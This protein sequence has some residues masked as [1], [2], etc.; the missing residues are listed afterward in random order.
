MLLIGMLNKHLLATVQTGKLNTPS[1]STVVSPVDSKDKE[2]KSKL[3]LCNP[4]TN[5]DL[6]FYLIDSLICFCFLI[7]DVTGQQV[8][9]MYVINPS[10][11][12][13]RK[14][15]S[16]MEFVQLEE[17]LKLYGD[18]SL[19]PP[20]NIAQSECARGLPIA[21]V[22]LFNRLIIKLRLRCR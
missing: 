2:Q 14:V 16:K 5:C 15:S 8:E 18:R 17:D 22:F 9:V 21:H 1:T 13:V 7:Q 19:E 6:I 11:F 20:T 4:K 10:L 3:N 12:Y